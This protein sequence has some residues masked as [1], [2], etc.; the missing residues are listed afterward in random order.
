L[1]GV[2]PA[3]LKNTNW[4]AQ[5]RYAKRVNVQTAAGSWINV[6]RLDGFFQW[7]NVQ[8]PQNHNPGNHLAGTL[9]ADRSAAEPC[10]PVAGGTYNASQ[11][12]LLEFDEKVGVS[13][14]WSR[15]GPARPAHGPTLNTTRDAISIGGVHFIGWALT[16]LG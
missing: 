5:P 9:L 4:P 10:R 12:L 3:T 1:L 13:S 11:W 15:P 8:T 6:S 2:L 7:T 16:D 14:N